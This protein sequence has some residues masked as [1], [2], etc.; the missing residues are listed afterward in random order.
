M[1]RDRAALAGQGGPIRVRP[2]TGPQGPLIDKPAM[3]IWIFAINDDP[4]QPDPRAG[5][6]RAPDLEAGCRA[7]YH[8]A[9]NLWELPPDAELPGAP[10]ANVNDAA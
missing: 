8:P 7:I 4:R 6:V 9:M 5:Y 10:D 2:L 1:S 3:P